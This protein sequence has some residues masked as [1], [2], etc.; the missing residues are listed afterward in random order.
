MFV[1]ELTGSC[2]N[3]ADQPARRLDRLGTPS[4][5]FLR[6]VVERGLEWS[7][8]EWTGLGWAGLAGSFFSFSRAKS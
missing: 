8:V 5:S 6:G 2:K 1:A 3:A 7:G 4:S